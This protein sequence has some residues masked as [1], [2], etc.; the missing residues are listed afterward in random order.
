VELVNRHVQAVIAEKFKQE[1]VAALSGKVHV[2][3]ALIAAYAMIPV[4]CKITSS[5]FIK[6]E[7]VALRLAAFLATALRAKPLLAKQLGSREDVQ[8]LV[9]QIKALRERMF[10]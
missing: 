8:P 1:E 3:Q 9:R 7:T 4:D 2:D 5:E 10:D 6:G